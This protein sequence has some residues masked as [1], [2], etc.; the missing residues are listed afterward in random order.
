MGN[1]INSKSSEKLVEG[2]SRS[3]SSSNPNPINNIRF[4]P[5]NSIPATEINHDFHID[6][7]S[8]TTH[9]H[10]QQQQVIFFFTFCRW[11]RFCLSCR[12][13][14]DKANAKFSVWTIFDDQIGTLIF[15]AQSKLFSWN[16]TVDRHWKCLQMS[17]RHTFDV[18]AYERDKHIMWAS[19][20]DDDTH[21]LCCARL[22]RCICLAGWLVRARTYVCVHRLA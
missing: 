22:V 17:L 8:T 20:I 13:H 6:S 15:W 16:Q 21:A 4:T 12:A 2:S 5:S 18:R 11:F 3:S 7:H 1:S 9:H 10:Q 14:G 19:A